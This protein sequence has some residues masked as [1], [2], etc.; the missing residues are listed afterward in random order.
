MPRIIPIPT[1]RVSDVFVR[2]R[3]LSQI[4]SDQL[5]L[6]RIQSAI[7]TGRRVNLPSDDAPA[8]LRAISLQS[9][10]E[11]KQQS[12]VNLQ[13]NQ[14]YLGATDTAIGGVS[15]LLASIRGT[16]LSVSDSTSTDLQRTAAAQEVSR[17]LDQMVDIGNH[18]FRGRY[19]FAG[20]STTVRPFTS[21]GTTVEYHGNEKS[22]LS[23][24]D[25]DLLFE[26]NLP[27]D[28]VFGAISEPVRGAVDL[29]P[30]LTDATR[31]SDLRGGKGISAGSIAVSD[32]LTT[33]IVDVSGASTIGEVAR[34]LETNPPAGRVVTARVTATGLTVELDAAGGGNLTIK[35]VGGGTTAGE[36]G[37]LDNLGGSTGPIIG[38]DLDPRL[39]I[40]TP[41]NDILGV[42]AA[43]TRNRPELPT[44]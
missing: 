2:Q 24:S 17:A 31:I 14:S 38:Q 29:N 23:F 25:I 11:R 19:L 18:Q 44:T 8:A 3:L 28:A 10:L 30:V 15:S 22:L 40:T 33:S 6:F 9:L 1:T 5:D 7:S 16:A 4:Q 39:S 13:T 32:G 42:R 37:I 41:L 34:L 12:Q 20:S 27:G 35:E 43:P 26:T 21:A 36:L